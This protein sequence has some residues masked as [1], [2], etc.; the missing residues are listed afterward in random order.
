MITIK[1]LN[2]HL[3]EFNLRDIN[4]HI[5]EGEYFVLLGPTGAGKSVLLE[6][7]AGLY[8]QD[9]GSMIISGQEVT[10]HDPE[11]RNLGAVSSGT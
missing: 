7:I 9:S 5:R 11:E 10:H 8:K 1:N 4:L 6:C 2:I 3:G